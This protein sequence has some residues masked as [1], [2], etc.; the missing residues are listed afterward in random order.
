MPSTTA[1]GPE[2]VRGRMVTLLVTVLGLAASGSPVALAGTGSGE[3]SAH[4]L[5]KSYPLHPGS[6]ATA[7][8]SP[9]GGAVPAHAA[10]SP[11]AGR[12]GPSGADGGDDGA[13]ARTLALVTAIL[14]AA[15]AA[16]GL[17]L[18][19]PRAGARRGP[20]RFAEAAPRLLASA[21]RLAAAGG[22]PPRGVR[23]PYRRDA[24]P[25]PLR[26]VAT[27]G[28]GRPPREA[29]RPGGQAPR[30]PDASRRWTAEMGWADG[31]PGPRFSV[32]ARDDERGE[33][34][35]LAE[36][37]PLEW[38]PS[39]S[40]AVAALTSAADDLARAVIGAGWIPLAPGAAWYAR[41]FAW[42]P[43]AEPVEP[44]PEQPPPA[45]RVGD[46]AVEP[47]ARA[48]VPPQPRSEPEGGARPDADAD[49]AHVSAR[50]RFR[51]RP[52][53][54]EAEALW[55]CEIRWNGGW[56]RSRLEVVA[57]APGGVR[58]T[59]LAASEPF[60]WM[61]HADP[62]P[63]DREIHAA[64]RNLRALLLADGWTEI[65]P[66]RGWYAHRFLWRRTGDPPNHL[67]LTQRDAGRSS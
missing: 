41:R 38:P 49:G 67:E 39:S 63:D 9:R 7:A 19:R 52:W 64:A 45:L 34:G 37:P 1:T 60:T 14:L 6:G 13:V 36:S 65:D 50:G 44:A 4:E 3:P 46:P 56:T 26:A 62:D 43:V 29:E 58:G 51:R 10:S 40:E 47:E 18:G 57:R 5:W 20:P 32:V 21:V 16:A 17:A 25:R 27:R 8:P 55:R 53:P 59:R 42:E 33:E 23:H 66:G 2:H 30:P 61:L 12:P 31:E 11:A 54:Q 28:R 22:T 48:P 15:A 35:V 24:G